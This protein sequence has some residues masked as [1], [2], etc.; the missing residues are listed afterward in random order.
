MVDKIVF[1]HENS[2][3]LDNINEIEVGLYDRE[4]CISVMYSGFTLKKT[5]RINCYSPSVC[6]LDFGSVTIGLLT[7]D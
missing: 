3:V 1:V 4:L 2:H 6:C 5:H 7:G